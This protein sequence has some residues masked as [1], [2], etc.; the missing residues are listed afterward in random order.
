[1]CEHCVWVGVWHCVAATADTS[2]V[3]GWRLSG[4]RLAAATLGNPLQGYTRAGVWILSIILDFYFNFFV[5]SVYNLQE[6]IEQH[7][8]IYA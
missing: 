8:L 1:M 7:N 4:T 3:Q 5:G 2:A 6:I